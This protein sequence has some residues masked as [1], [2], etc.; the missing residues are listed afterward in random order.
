MTF[1]RVRDMIVLPPDGLCQKY[2]DA[3]EQSL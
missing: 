2:L 1:P 3:V